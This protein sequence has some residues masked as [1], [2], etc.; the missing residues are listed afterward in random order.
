LTSASA[1][2]TSIL[3]ETD[4]QSNDVLV[5]EPK[6]RD[7]ATRAVQILDLVRQSLQGQVVLTTDLGLPQPQ[8][9]NLSKLFSGQFTTL[10][11][12]LPAFTADGQFDETQFPDPTFGGT[13]PDLTQLQ[14]SQILLGSD[15]SYYPNASSQ[16]A[17]DAA[18]AQQH[19]SSSYFSSSPGSSYCVLDGC[20]CIGN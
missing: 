19:C 7:S 17:C 2:I 1:A 8:R 16:A 18:A 11:S 13:A 14:L 5:I 4:D 9:L 20:L 15:C 3:N 6:G 12:F 10:R